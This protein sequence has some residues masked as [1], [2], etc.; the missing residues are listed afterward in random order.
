MKIWPASRAA[1]LAAAVS[2]IAP[3]GAQ[4]AATPPIP[5][6][7][8]Q[9]AGPA[10]ELGPIEGWIK[11]RYSVLADGTTTNVHVIDVVPPR[12]STKETIAAVNHW[13]FTP[14]M[15]GGRA[16]DWHNNESAVIN[17]GAPKGCR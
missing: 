12:F 3:V 10:T 16:I 11:V 15:E 17:V 5:L 6:E 14:A 4:Q 8:S 9:P 7:Q 1:L 13:K 2:F